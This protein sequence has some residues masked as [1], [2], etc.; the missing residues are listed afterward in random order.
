MGTNYHNEALRKQRVV[1]RQRES[2][3]RMV[4]HDT[5]PESAAR[6]ELRSGKK[7]VE[8]VI[9][10][11]KLE[12]HRVHEDGFAI[13][14]RNRQNFNPHVDKAYKCLY[15]AKDNSQYTAD[16]NKNNWIANKQIESYDLMQKING[17]FHV[18]VVLATPE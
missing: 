12:K 9:R 13:R 1:D 3:M 17:S 2:V 4:N 7:A 15:P 14:Y 8:D 16:S 6:N 18:D 11:P 10:A 5:G